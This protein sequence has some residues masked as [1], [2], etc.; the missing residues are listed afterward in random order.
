MK[1]HPMYN[2]HPWRTT[3]LVP[4]FLLMGVYELPINATGQEGQR[5]EDF[6][7]L[8]AQNMKPGPQMGGVSGWLFSL[9]ERMGRWFGWDDDLMTL[10]IPGEATQTTLRERL[11]PQELNAQHALYQQQPDLSEGPMFQLVYRLANEQL[12]ELSNQTVHAMMHLVWAKRADGGYSPLFAVLY[13]PRGWLGRFYMQM[14]RPFQRF[15]VHPALCRR[16]GAMWSAHLNTLSS[17]TLN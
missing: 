3:T 10:P 14:I 15:V 13:K 11:T 16:M 5:F 2:E 12:A 7:H 6:C 4:D 1:H 8:M 9:R 17:T